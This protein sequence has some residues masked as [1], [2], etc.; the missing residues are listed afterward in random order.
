[1]SDKDLEWVG[2]TVWKLRMGAEK[3]KRYGRTSENLMEY[4]S[5]LSLLPHRVIEKEMLEYIKEKSDTIL[6]FINAAER[7]S[8]LEELI[9]RGIQTILRDEIPKLRD[10]MRL[11]DG[12]GVNSRHIS[13]ES[14]G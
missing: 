13:E 14:S 4:S 9:S 2:D 1:M 6:A 7:S 11:E 10:I 12:I 5:L 3:L 8:H